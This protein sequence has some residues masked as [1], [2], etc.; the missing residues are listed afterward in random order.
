MKQKLTLDI[1]VI[2]NNYYYSHFSKLDQNNV[3]IIINVDHNIISE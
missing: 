1:H 2:F 3:S